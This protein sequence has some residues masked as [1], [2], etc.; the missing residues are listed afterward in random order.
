L[1]D[2]RVELLRQLVLNTQASY[3]VIPSQR[4]VRGLLRHL[5]ESGGALPYFF[6][7]FK[8]RYTINSNL[9]RR[10]LEFNIWVWSPGDFRSCVLC[11]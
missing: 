6:Y 4:F 2:N 1:G 10:F 3:G 9:H 5:N 11:L 8:R 7:W